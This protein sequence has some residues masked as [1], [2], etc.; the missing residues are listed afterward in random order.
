MGYIL[1]SPKYIK[2]ES[3][4]N[5]IENWHLFDA[6]II[7]DEIENNFRCIQ[8]LCNHSEIYNN[9]YYKLVYGNSAEVEA[10]MLKNSI[11]IKRDIIAGKIE[12][13]LLKEKSGCNKIYIDNNKKLIKNEN[14][15]VFS[16]KSDLNEKYT[17]YYFSVNNIYYTN[18]NKTFFYS[19]NEEVIRILAC[20]LGRDICGVCMSKLYGD[21]DTKE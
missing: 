7:E 13:D 16:I 4:E 6:K 11:M 14:F 15:E 19:D 12:F 18:R 5:K 20:T 10:N 21:L 8:I 2:S 17:N 9:K 3:E 1:L